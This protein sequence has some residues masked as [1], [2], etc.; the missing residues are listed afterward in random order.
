MI[1]A[2]IEF[3]GTPSKARKLRIN[4]EKYDIKKHKQEN[5]YLVEPH[6]PRNI[7][8]KAMSVG[9]MSTMLWLYTARN[10]LFGKSNNEKETAEQGEA[11]NPSKPKN[12]DKTNDS[13][14]NMESY[15][16]NNLEKQV[17]EIY[18]YNGKGK[19]IKYTYNMDKDELVP[20]YENDLKKEEAKTLEDK[21]ND[22]DD[23]KVEKKKGKNTLLYVIGALVG[24]YI[25]ADGLSDGEWFDFNFKKKNGDDDN[26]VI[27]NPDLTVKCY[28]LKRDGSLEIV[29]DANIRIGSNNYTASNGEHTVI[30]I[31]TGSFEVNYTDPSVWDKIL[32]VREGTE[33]SKPNIEKRDFRDFSSPVTVNSD[34]TVYLIKLDKEIHVNEAKKYVDDGYGM[35]KFDIAAG[36]TLPVV[37]NNVWGGDITEAKRMIE[38]NC[39]NIT[40]AAH[41]RLTLN[42]QTTEAS[43]TRMDIYL[44]DIESIESIHGEYLN[45][46]KITGAVVELPGRAEETDFQVTLQEIMGGLTHMGSLYYGPL[47]NGEG[48][49]D[50]GKDVMLLYVNADAETYWYASESSAQTAAAS[51]SI[52]NPGVISS[53]SRSAS[54]SKSIQIGKKANLRAS[55]SGKGSDVNLAFGADYALD[56]GSISGYF[57]LTNKVL[58]ANYN[59]M[60]LG[61]AVDLK[62]RYTRSSFDRQ[63][64]FETGIKP[65]RNTN[66]NL[67]VNNLLCPENN[68][69]LNAGYDGKIFDASVA[70]NKD[71]IMVQ[72]DVNFNNAGAF[73]NQAYR[74]FDN[75]KATNLGLSYRIGNNQ[76]IVNANMIN[77]DLTGLN[78][79]L[80]GQK[81]SD[82]INLGYSIA[83][84][85]GY[86]KKPEIKISL[87][88]QF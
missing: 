65:T 25:L 71:N 48:L 49:T 18:G 39:T 88:L 64:A 17:S 21:V 85:F 24:A 82:N 87:N 2:G 78:L 68:V 7:G 20:V 3:K 37:I 59:Q 16:F 34:R 41:G 33:S 83:G 9:L 70:V 12:P 4:D 8:K 27:V 84:G 72:A 40:N 55:M 79:G 32:F 5:V 81:I 54:L 38:K 51:N 46:N 56:N 29:P 61:G 43:G 57:D 31:G 75:S 73:I 74:S 15:G 67:L 45:G 66:I 22:A 60:L 50:L 35:Y 42:P 76:F 36:G 6:K 63:I 69:F 58:R 52:R 14:V 86:L 1:K 80:A 10:N 23:A 30:D 11:Y 53:E 19:L 44:K 77:K 28:K 62:L 47:L 13:S 26:H